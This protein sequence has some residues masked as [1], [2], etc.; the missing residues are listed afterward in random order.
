LAYLIGLGFAANFLQIYQFHNG[1]MLENVMAATHSRQ[2]ELKSLDEFHHVREGDIMDRSP[3]QSLEKLLAVHSRSGE[4][5][6]VNLERGIAQLVQGR[7]EFGATQY[8]RLPVTA[9]VA[10]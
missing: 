7:E 5:V 9:A 4:L 8:R 1:R 10:P 6:G 2:S 3:G